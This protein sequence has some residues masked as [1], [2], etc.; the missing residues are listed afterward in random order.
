MGVRTTNQPSTVKSAAAKPIGVTPISPLRRRMID[1]MTLRN[2]SPTTP[3][4]CLH[5][6]AAYGRYFGRSPD[7]LGLKDVRAYQVH[8]AGKRV[9]WA[10]LNQI[11]CAL[12]LDIRR[13]PTIVAATG[14]APSVRPAP[15]GSGSR[16]ARPICCRSPLSTSYSRCRLRLRP[17]PITIRRWSTPSCSRRQPRRCKRSPG[18]GGRDAAL[19]LHRGRSVARRQGRRARQL[20]RFRDRRHRLRQIFHRFGDQPGGHQ[21]QRRRHRR[22][23]PLALEDRERDLQR[24]EKSRL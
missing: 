9:A 7:R 5:A 8:L 12:R 2:L 23:R 18:Q 11:G 10:T 19:S 4:S 17:S 1:D 24:D 14:I 22:G 15:R 13:S 3:R 16:P 20:D 21:S 6:V